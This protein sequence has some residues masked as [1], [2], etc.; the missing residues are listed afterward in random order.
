[1]PFFTLLYDLYRGG[2]CSYGPSLSFF[3]SV[4]LVFL[5]FC[6]KLVLDCSSATNWDKGIV[7]T[8]HLR[9]AS[10]GSIFGTLSARRA[11]RALNQ[12]SGVCAVFRSWDKSPL[13]H[14]RIVIL[15]LIFI[16]RFMLKQAP[17]VAKPFYSIFQKK[18]TGI[19]FFLAWST[20]EKK[21]F[22]AQTLCVPYTSLQAYILRKNRR[23]KRGPGSF[24]GGH[25]GRSP[26]RLTW[27]PLC[28]TQLFTEWSNQ[29]AICQ[30]HSPSCHLCS[31]YQ[32]GGERHSCLYQAWWSECIKRS[33]LLSWLVDV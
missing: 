13:A 29:K 18:W 33:L 21:K 20:E 4:G 11:V 22:R 12:G 7:F 9:S 5:L 24:G 10:D 30:N 3:S 19:A 16:I 1:M 15:R 27:A 8:F 14:I 28:A 17:G 6:V 32:A 2:V 26:L 23:K 31:S 25:W